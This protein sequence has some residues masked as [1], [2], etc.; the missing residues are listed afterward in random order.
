MDI[1]LNINKCFNSAVNYE[2]VL[3]SAPINTTLFLQDPFISGDSFACSLINF[4][5][6]YDNVM[7][8]SFKEKSPVFDDILN[9]K[10]DY[11]DILI[12]GKA[13]FNIS[14]VKGIY[15]VFKEKRTPLYTEVSLGEGK[16]PSYIPSEEFLYYQQEC[17]VKKGDYLFT[18][19]GKASFATSKLKYMLL[20]AKNQ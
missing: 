7:D 12:L 20:Q 3:D 9:C 10:C 19:G 14:H 17:L 8:D 18:I 1:T 11:K 2:L 16:N 13:N 4:A 6:N 5:L 15:L